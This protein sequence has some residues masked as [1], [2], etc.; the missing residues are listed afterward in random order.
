MT[1]KKKLIVN[2]KV[3]TPDGFTGKVIDFDGKRNLY[4]VCVETQRLWE[5]K[6]YPQSLL[7]VTR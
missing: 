2:Q 1:D 6:W 5:L 7:K 3:R 4:G